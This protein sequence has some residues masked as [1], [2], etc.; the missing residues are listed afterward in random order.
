MNSLPPRWERVLSLD[1]QKV[2]KFGSGFWRFWRTYL[3]G[4]LSFMCWRKGIHVGVRHSAWR[5]VKER[6]IEMVLQV[7]GKYFQLIDA[8]P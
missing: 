5:L 8:Y 2:K 4:R 3:G 7:I 1:L 6:E